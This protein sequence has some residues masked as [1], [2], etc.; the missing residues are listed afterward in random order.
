[1]PRYVVDCATV[2]AIT[3]APDYAIPEG[4]ELGESLPLEQQVELIEALAYYRRPW[5]DEARTAPP[6]GT[7]VRP[8]HRGRD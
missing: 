8:G 5:T 1:M 7:A 6:W 2:L 3:K 4:V